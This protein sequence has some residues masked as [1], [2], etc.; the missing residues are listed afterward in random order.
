MNMVIVP[1]TDIQLAKNFKLSEFACRH[2]GKVLLPDMRGVEML[3]QIRSFINSNI[4]VSGYR[5]PEYNKMLIAQGIKASPD[6]KHMQGIAWDISNP[7]GKV[8]PEE[9]FYIAVRIG[10]PGV[11]LY[12][13]H[14]HVDFG[15][16]R[17]WDWREVNRGRVFTFKY[18]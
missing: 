1:G 9:L 8:T 18:Q 17:H 14:V 16:A 7:P 2:C 15:P 3:Q 5:C 4:K 13:E 6:S 11:G 12:D 10:F